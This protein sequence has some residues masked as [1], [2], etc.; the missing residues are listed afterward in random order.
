MNKFK[1]IANKVGLTVIEAK[2]IFFL[3]VVFFIGLFSYYLIYEADA[4]KPKNF[5]YKNAD[6]IFISTNNKVKIK[7]SF[8]NDVKKVDSEQE[9]LDFSANNISIKDNYKIDINKASIKDFQKLPGIGIK[10]AK[11]IIEL[12][13][14]KGSFKK[15]KGLLMVKGIGKFKFKKIKNFIFVAN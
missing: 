15:V 9:L 6:S 1:K 4:V 8:K 5:S 3:I 11:K 7:S 10:T 14:T 2:I 12:R 13:K